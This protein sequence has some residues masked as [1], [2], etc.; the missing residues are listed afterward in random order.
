MPC[1]LLRCSRLSRAA[2]GG[3]AALGRREDSLSSSKGVF[4]TAKLRQ[5]QIVNK[6]S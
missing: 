6:K 1:S 5:K 3:Q 2:Y 4:A